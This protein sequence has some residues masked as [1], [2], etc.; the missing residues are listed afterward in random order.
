VE[1]VDTVEFWV[2]G[3]KVAECPFE[4]WTLT[5]LNL[6]VDRVI[7]TVEASPTEGGTV[8]GSDTYDCCTHAA[9]TATAAGGWEF[10]GWTTDDMDEIAEPSSESTTVHMDK[11]KTVTANFQQVG[12]TYD[13]TVTSDGC[14]PIDVTYVGGGGTVAADDSQTFTGILEGT[15]VTVSA[16][17]SDPCCQFDSWSDGGA[18]THVITMD[19]NKSVTATCSVLTYDLTVISNVC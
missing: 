17:D 12:V 8:T 1:G 10:D 2:L 18:Q 11:D 14:C 9:I 13:L 19:A 15:D 5:S 7:L 16:D 3:Y 6:V 4:V